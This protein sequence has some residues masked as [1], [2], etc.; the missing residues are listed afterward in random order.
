MRPHPHT[1]L[2]LVE[3]LVVL[4]IIGSLLG[5]LL[6]AV[7]ASREAA[8]QSQCGNNLRQLGLAVHG[9]HD[10]RSAFPLARQ[11]TRRSNGPSS[12][13]VLPAHLVGVADDPISYPLQ[14][15]QLGSW[16]LR[17]QPYMESGEVV[18]LWQTPATLNE[19]YAMFWKVSRIR[20][21]GYVCPSDAQAVQGP[22][23]WGYGFTSYLAVSGNDE[24]VDEAGH[25]SN[26]TNGVFPTLAWSW[27]PRPRVTMK[28]IVAG[29]S[30]VVMAGER[31][32]SSTLY[33]GRWNM[34]DFDTVM[35]NPNLEFSVVP[36]GRDGGPC[37]APGYYAPASPDDPCAVNH[38]WSFHP[39]GGRWLLADGSVRTIGYDAGT[40]IMLAMSSVDGGPGGGLTLTSPEDAR[41]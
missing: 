7:Q 33:Y 13:S 8:R 12:F 4:A 23:P 2:T 38:F 18:G 37:P 6:P 36:T 24:H 20:I 19:A 26:A 27:A 25:A 22:S 34:T 21:P 14:P 40:T 35:A 28:N 11:A 31:P 15:D 3:L 1:G 10:A 17:V 5:L 39:N 9:H 41:Q 29:T 32:P 16:L 30:N